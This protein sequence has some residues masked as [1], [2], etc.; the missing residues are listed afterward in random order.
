MIKKMAEG[1]SKT[2]ALRCLKS[3]SFPIDLPDLED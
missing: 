1:K 2:E 3:I